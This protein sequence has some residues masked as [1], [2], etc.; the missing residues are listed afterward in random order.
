MFLSIQSEP[1]MRERHFLH[2]QKSPLTLAFMGPHYWAQVFFLV[3][4]GNLPLN[5]YSLLTSG[6]SPALDKL[7]QLWSYPLVSVNVCTWG[8]MRLL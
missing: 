7:F 6:R 1:T 4:L 3:P 8:I 5:V 2:P